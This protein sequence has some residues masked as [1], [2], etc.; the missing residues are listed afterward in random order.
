M[1][2]TVYARTILTGNLSGSPVSVRY[3]RDD[4][5]FA[6]TTMGRVPWSEVLAGMPVREFRAWRGCRHYSGWYWSSTTG[7][8]VVYES[9]LELAR[10]L[11]ADRDGDV[12]AIAA[13][14]MLLE[15]ADGCRVR[16]HVPDLLLGHRDGSL[17]VVDVKAA[18]R[19]SDPAVVAQFAWTRRLCA[20]HGLGFEV[21]SGTNPIE[22]ENLRFLAGYRRPGTVQAELILPVLHAALAPITVA[23]LERSMAALAP[24]TV[25]RPVILRLL[26]QSRLTADLT[27]PLSGDT[28]VTSAEVPA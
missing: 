24:V 3:R 11:L 13:Q 19:L 1:N 10:I 5:M 4:G 16:R 21:W 18:A 25:V 17:T 12:V 22:L 26:W 9:R 7:A 15:G 2:E 8:H 20:E 28:V 23:E 14:P 6:D 27:R